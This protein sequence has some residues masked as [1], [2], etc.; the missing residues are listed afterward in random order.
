MTD[1]D[2]SKHVLIGYVSDFDNYVM[3][4]LAGIFI[5][6]YSMGSVLFFATAVSAFVSHAEGYVLRK[7]YVDVTGIDSSSAIRQQVLGDNFKN[8]CFVPLQVMPHILHSSRAL[9]AGFR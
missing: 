9:S 4:D 6:R 5:R 3:T 7:T 8:G 2:E 1:G